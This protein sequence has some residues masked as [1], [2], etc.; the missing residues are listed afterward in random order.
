MKTTFFPARRGT[1]TTFFAALFLLPISLIPAS[2][3]MSLG[4]RAGVNLATWSVNDPVAP[5]DPQSVLLLQVGMPLLVPI[6]DYLAVQPE[7]TFLQKGVEEEEIDQ[8]STTTVQ[9]VINYIELPILLKGTFGSEKV[10]AHL[11]AGPSL[12]YA[13]NG[14]AKGTADILGTKITIEEDI[15]FEEDE[16]SRLDLG[17]H[18]GAAVLVPVG[19]GDLMFDVRYMLGLINIDDAQV[20]NI[21]AYNRGLALSIGYLFP[22]GQ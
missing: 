9:A 12:G 22:L 15:D 8:G 6:N 17:L 2:A 11:F 19:S 5:S 4:F 1:L 3:Q 20:N 14:K 21:E 16:I 10:K 7:L 13:L 18:L